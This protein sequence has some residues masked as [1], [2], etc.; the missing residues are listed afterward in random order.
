MWFAKSMKTSDLSKSSAILV[1][2][3]LKLSKIDP[4]DLGA[5]RDKNSAEKQLGALLT[6]ISEQ[7][8]KLYAENKRSLLLVF[9]A[10]DTGGKDGAIRCVL[11]GINPEGVHVTSFKVP[12]INDLAHDF[13]WRIHEAAPARGMIGVW[14]RS[15]YEDVL[16]TRVHNVIDKDTWQGRYQDIAAFEKMLVRAGTTIRKFYLH[17]DRDEQKQRLQAR[18]D[19][20]SKHWKFNEGDLKERALWDGY[21]EA[22]EDA[23]SATSTPEAPW[24][25]IPAN[26]KW[27]RNVAIA[28]I[29]LD[30]LKKMAPAFPAVQFDASKIHLD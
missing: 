22:Y 7:Q 21:M 4:D 27:A 3:K 24:F 10:M 28:Q 14:N 9:Q 29:V 5:A 25:V 20:P 11:S 8:V 30:T 18:L 2:G 1:D 16:V 6:Q 12:T 26:K 15:H 17:I 19:D 23:L 13:L